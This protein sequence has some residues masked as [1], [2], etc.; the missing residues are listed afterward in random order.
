MT[1][2]EAVS[3]ADLSKLSSAQKRE[4]LAKL[5]EDNAAAKGRTAPM[6]FAQERLWFLHQ[7]QPANPVYNIPMS[8]PMGAVDV[9]R[10]ESALQQVVQR[11]EP[12][13]TTF[14]L[15]NGKPV[16]Y[17]SNNIDVPFEVIDL[18][19]RPE[20]ERQA[21][22]SQ[23]AQ[24]DAVTPFD[25]EHGPLFRVFLIRVFD[26]V[27]WLLLNLHHIAADGWSLS[28]MF[29]EL[30]FLYQGRKLPPL[31]VSYADYAA[32]QRKEMT[33][34]GFQARV[35]TV[36]SRLRG[37][38]PVISLPLDR[39][40]P[41]IESFRGAEYTFEIDEAVASGLRRLS[42]KCRTTLFMTL[43]A[44]LKVVLSRY[45]GCDDIVIGS[46]AANRTSAEYES[47]IGVFVNTLVLRTDLSGNPS[48]TQLLGRV[49]EVTTEAFAH[50][51][52]PFEKIVEE[53]MPVR[54]L[55]HNPVF[56]VMAVLQNLPQVSQASTSNNEQLDDPPPEQ[57][58][59]ELST[60]TSK[61]DL[62][63]T[64][65]ESEVGVKGHVEYN[66]DL[67]E[68][69]TV[70]QLIQHYLGVLSHVV[71]SP[72]AEIGTIPLGPETTVSPR[73][74]QHEP[75]PIK[76]VL[77]RLDQ[78]AREHDETLT[79]QDRETS[80]PVSSILRQADALANELADAGIQ[81]GDRVA[82]N[83][84][85]GISWLTSLVAIMKADATAVLPLECDAEVS[86]DLV[87][88]R[89]YLD[90]Q[91][92]KLSERV[93]NS[94]RP[95]A[96]PLWLT[97]NELERS[98]VSHTLLRS[99]S[100]LMQCVESLGAGPWLSEDPVGV[101][102][103]SFSPLAPFTV[104]WPL[105]CGRSID[106]TISVQ[107]PENETTAGAVIC[108]TESGLCIHDL[109]VEAPTVFVG[110]P[111]PP[112]LFAPASSSTIVSLY[113]PRLVG[114]PVASGV[115]TDHNWTVG[116]S[117]PLFDLDWVLQSMHE[118]VPAK[119]P[120]EL[121]L[122]STALE[123]GT[124]PMIPTGDW[125]IRGVDG[126]VEFLGSQDRTRRKRGLLADPKLTEQWLAL[127]NDI[128]AC[129]VRFEQRVGK[130]EPQ[131]VAYTAPADQLSEEDL[132]TRAADI[133]PAHLRPDRYRLLPALPSDAAGRIDV[134]ELPAVPDE[135][136]T[137]Q[138][139]V[140]AT[141]PI[142]A[143]LSRI[144]CEVLGVSA[145]G[146]HDNFF[147]LGG[148]SLASIQVLARI[149]ERFDIDL[150]VHQLFEADTVAA[151]AALLSDDES[152]DC[153]T[154]A[155]SSRETSSVSDDPPREDQQNQETTTQ[156][157]P[158][159]YAQERLWFLE[160]LQPGTPLYNLAF[161]VV[162]PQPLDI[163][164]VNRA[165]TEIVNRHD[166]L[167][168]SFDLH[169]GVPR[170]I[171]H[172]PTNFEAPVIDLRD[173][174][175][176]VAAERL[177]QISQQLA[178]VPFD[179][180][181]FPLLRCTAVQTKD[182]SFSLLCCCHHIISDG[183]SVGVFMQE[184]QH[185]IACY[186]ANREPALPRLPMQYAESA[187]RQRELLQGETLARL[188]HYWENQLRDLPSTPPIR[189]DH[190]RPPVQ[191]FR[192]SSHHFRMSADTYRKLKDLCRKARVTPFMV[193]LAAVKAVL[194]RYSGE[195]DIVMGTPIANRTMPNT[196][197]LIGFFANTLVL[198]TQ[199]EPNL[200]FRDL[201]LR[202][203][204]VSLE[205]QSHQ[206]LPFERLV[207]HLRPERSLSSNPLFQVMFIFQS[208]SRTDAG[209]AEFEPDESSAPVHTGTSKF[210]LTLAIAES[211]DGLLCSCEYN[212]DIL[213]AE[214][215]K[216]LSGILDQMLTQAVA[217]P[218]TALSDL[219]L[220]DEEVEQIKRLS[221]ETWQLRDDR[222]TSLERFQATASSQPGKTAL[223]DP[224]RRWT[225]AELN[226]AANQLAR[227]LAECGV[228]SDDRVLHAFARGGEAIAAVLAIL[229]IGAAYVPIDVSL[230]LERLQ[231]LV[232]QS[233][234][235]CLLV[236]SE[237]VAAKLPLH[238]LPSII[239]D[240][241]RDELSK[242]HD[243]NI[244]LAA[245]PLSLVYVIFTS[246]STG[247]PKG[248]EMCHRCV[249]NLLSW[250][251]N[252]FGS[253]GPRTLHFAP[254]SFDV[255]YQ[256]IFAALGNE[257]TLIVAD[258]DQRRDPAELLRL[259]QHERVERIYMPFV[260]LQQLAQQ[261]VI[262]GCPALNL[263]DIVAAGETLKISE[264]IRRWIS[265]LDECRLHNQYGPSE[266]HIVTHYT[267]PQDA[268]QWLR[269]PSIGRPTLG[270]TALIVDKQLN[271]VPAG[272]VG[273]LCIGGQ[274]V[275]RGYL[276]NPRETAASFVP[277]PLDDSGERMYRTGDLARFRPDGELEFLGR[278]DDQIKIR[279]F[280]VE[281]GEIEHALR[282]CP[283]IRDAVVVC[284]TDAASAERKL[285]AFLLPHQDFDASVDLH[286][287]LSSKLPAYMVPSEFSV[288]D[289]FPL[290][291]SGK[292][293]RRRLASGDGR[294]LQYVREHI[295]AR[296]PVEAALVEIYQEVLQIDDVSVNDDF[297]RLGGHSLSTVKVCSRIRQRLGVDIPVHCIFDAP[298][299]AQMAVT[300]I[301]RQSD[302]INEN[303]LRGL[304]SDLA[305]GG[306]EKEG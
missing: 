26:D 92:I 126:R 292:V 220:A 262:Q 144:W 166:V 5:L 173:Q 35:A 127:E 57:R 28:L 282:E 49:R 180:T 54:S 233:Q 208:M 155:D 194:A 213:E 113:A 227:R 87:N 67:F 177:M 305:G 206:D 270:A 304:L 109:T 8:L 243:G 19:D 2:S 221:A 190:P 116:L 265:S 238:N 255:S 79:L 25:L 23:Y 72:D 232:S 4:L 90:N 205:A 184:L 235:S 263:R 159:S 176:D 285:V 133:L 62:T 217:H 181:T 124:R 244:G 59:E 226:S 151:L 141:T 7:L 286:T 122:L 247:I 112:E 281:P 301:E 22:A 39:P 95:T 216:R 43:L 202:V 182:D 183:W 138:E 274:G 101:M 6:S 102:T 195:T 3:V 58:N 38:P 74:K 251:D 145:V 104:L 14:R 94:P 277:N 83:I 117:D 68:H 211:P 229:K 47:M 153:D 207:E 187:A 32:R 299:P 33:S 64:L 37:A 44:G 80:I 50:Q 302:Q 136:G 162:I 150:S 119:V 241:E 219:P 12:L 106:L 252:V 224:A 276:G 284:D 93:E 65:A 167:R 84:P 13:R 264:D 234:A 280:R 199:V 98:E 287:Q 40:R 258:E 86:S 157:H 293:D 154:R 273:E 210:D 100:V 306:H 189:F 240:S 297:F 139:F 10:L 78:V 172:G 188:N 143:T 283:G 248:V 228:G 77:D 260:A 147:D 146:I 149:K 193:A 174:T 271:P 222:G 75:L 110:S 261:A 16:Q 171:V 71:E 123:D 246:G 60:G 230:P 130:P 41:D 161:G 42:Q 156:A 29:N 18:R 142:E 236:S 303:Q 137:H 179:F 231:Y 24:Q 56:Q 203:K 97:A 120:A 55:S 300:V 105:L 178:T 15:E 132:Q 278:N 108:D 245:D 88:C 52:V 152:P 198:R 289:E 69:E 34:A 254:M 63:W 11:H 279:G 288:R 53:L 20:D 114:F 76:S 21:I 192:G 111:P 164:I 73:R 99:P 266:T 148:N 237:E 268:D 163:E 81:S 131:L 223:I 218:D 135:P 294:K 134:D 31:Q 169:N 259:I 125:A 212:T 45:S 36:V 239:I 257:G 9:Q 17:I 91:K 118:S 51:D 129:A 250:Q 291:G 165:I 201:V 197:G 103:A 191:G 209:H 275:G 61:V 267:L 296:N 82:L 46:P 256:E 107:A 1:T 70:K 242:L 225:Y 121:M 269:L 185:L 158:L 214:T 215:I 249:E 140:P 196:E 85:L 170:Q 200:T 160:Q 128:Q 175:P 295:A 66:V 204:Q 290:T 115:G 27:N 272:A 48:F 96:H 186:A 30:D 298:T 168:T 253:K 89:V